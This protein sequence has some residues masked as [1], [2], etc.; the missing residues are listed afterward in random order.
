MKDW[1]MTALIRQKNTFLYH[2]KTFYCWDLTLEDYLYINIDLEWWLDKIFMEFNDQAPLL[3]TRQSREFMRILL[4]QEN[5]WKNEDLMDKMTDTQKKIQAFKNKQ[6]KDPK[7]EVEDMLDDFH[8]IEG[9]MMH[10]LKQHLSEMRK[11][12]YQY[13]MKQYKDLPYTTWQKE[14]EKNRNSKSPDKKWFKKEFLD[15][16]NK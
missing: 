13:F 2:G 4:W 5:E 6:K 10:Y 12:P 3:N 11:W 8:I 7:K 16:Y 15:F 14:Y 9:Q 1:K